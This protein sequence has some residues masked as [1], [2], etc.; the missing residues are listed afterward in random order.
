MHPK[1]SCNCG[2]ISFEITAPIKKVVNCHCNFC[3]RMNGSSFSTY[4]IVSETDFQILSGNSNLKHHEVSQNG[5]KFFCNNCGSPIF[6]RNSKFP[7]LN[8]IY[9]GI[10]DNPSLYK[11]Q[12]NI[13]CDTK[14]GWVDDISNID[15]FIQT[16]VK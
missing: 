3:R 16:V 8:I 10:L 6:N 13:F 4:V 9:L 12:V 11:P 1:G 5:T 7:G 15:S 2:S 14:L